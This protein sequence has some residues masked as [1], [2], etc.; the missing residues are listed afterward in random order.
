MKIVMRTLI[1]ADIEKVWEH[2][3]PQYAH[4]GKWASAVYDSKAIKGSAVANTAPV[5]GRV[6]ET[7]L[8]P[9]E[10]RIVQYDQ[11]SKS[12]AY[13]AKGKKMP[14][15]VKL[16]QGSWQLSTLSSGK[17]EVTMSLEAE[18]LFP[19]SMLMGWIMKRQF[20]QVIN[21]TLEE[22][23]YFIEHNN[24]HARKLESLEKLVGT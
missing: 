10:E 6:C 20:S 12:L 15:F 13:Q 24:V 11:S 21:E 16:L 22:L 4:V 23:K 1:A 7:S 9:F 3:G 17:T 19:F 8:G 14:F 18:L 2:I 5:A